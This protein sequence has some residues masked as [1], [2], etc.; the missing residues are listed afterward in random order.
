MM[1]SCLLSCIFDCVVFRN[2]EW[3]V[4]LAEGRR[5]TFNSVLAFLA[6]LVLHA[7]R[8]LAHDRK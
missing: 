3:D 6:R 5:L 8:T 7:A 1:Q 2:V 4:P